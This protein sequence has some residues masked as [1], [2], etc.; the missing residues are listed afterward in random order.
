MSDSEH[1]TDGTR[2]YYTGKQTEQEKYMDIQLQQILTQILK[3][4]IAY[5]DQK[6]ST[7]LKA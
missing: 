7:C 2:D 5:G 6:S 4:H 3:L 1:Y